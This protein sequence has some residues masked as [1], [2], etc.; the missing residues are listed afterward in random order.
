MKFRDDIHNCDGFG[1]RVNA[2]KGQAALQIGE[3]A[4]SIEVAPQNPSKL[5]AGGVAL[6]DAAISEHGAD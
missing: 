6:A 1:G 3:A 2:V 5:D 4:R